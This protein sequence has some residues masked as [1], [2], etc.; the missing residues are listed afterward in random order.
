ME[1]H[2]TTLCIPSYS[3]MTLFSMKAWGKRQVE[4]RSATDCYS[5]DD[6]ARSR[7]VGRVENGPC[8]TVTLSL[9]ERVRMS[10]D[11]VDGLRSPRLV[12]D[13]GLN[14]LYV[15]DGGDR[16]WIAGK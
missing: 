16:R 11:P 7:A 3:H 2:T 10:L 12:G 9:D 13:A 1:T 6:V 5:W 8:S 14:D 4:T 15:W